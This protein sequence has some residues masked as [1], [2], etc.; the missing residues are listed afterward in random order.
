MLGSYKAAWL[1]FYR[2]H[3]VRFVQVMFD[4]TLNVLLFYILTLKQPLSLLTFSCSSAATVIMSLINLSKFIF[5]IVYKFNFVID[6]ICYIN[7]YN[8][9]GYLIINQSFDV[10]YD[11]QIC[12]MVRFKRMCDINTCILKFPQNAHLNMVVVYV[13]IL[14]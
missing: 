8:W 3:H 14:L 12:V 4:N 2:A 6:I 9:V 5:Y 13:S 1:C 11:I 7:A 10:S